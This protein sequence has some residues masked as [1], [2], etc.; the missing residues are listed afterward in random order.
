MHNCTVIIMA[1]GQGSRLKRL[2]RFVSK[3]ALIVFDQPMLMR[4]LDHLLEAGFHSILISTNPLHYPML[5]ALVSSYRETIAS[6]GI[7]DADL[8]VLNNPAH[9]DGPTEGLLAALRHVHT[10]RALMVLV[11]EFIR[12]NSFG[13]FAERVTDSH[14]YCEV[15]EWIDIEESKRGGYVTVVDGFV[16]SHIEATGI[17]NAESYPSTGTSLMNTADV[18]MDAEAFLQKQPGASSIGDFMEYRAAVLKR[19][20]RALMGPDF[21]NINTPD[22]LLLANLYAAMERHGAGSTV[23]PEMARLADFMRKSI[24]EQY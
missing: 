17:L 10:P 3:A 19:Q 13:A 16:V 22:F 20:V 14:E 9:V 21:V 11:D 18:I 15:S 7:A 24:H 5:D 8:R 23:Y 4:H 2:G 6:E 1:G 12:S